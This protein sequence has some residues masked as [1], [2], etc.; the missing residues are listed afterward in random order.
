MAKWA[1]IVNNTVAE[2]INFDPTGRFPAFMEWVS[3]PDTVG[4]RWTYNRSTNS[5]EEF[6][7]PKPTPQPEL[8]ANEIGK[9]PSGGPIG[10]IPQ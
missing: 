1:R 8:P 5:F 10:P 3:C 6:V 4:E 2:I 9:G 7:L